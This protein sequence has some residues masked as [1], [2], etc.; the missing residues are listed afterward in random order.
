ML[1]QT[2]L[3]LAVLLVV[4]F[5]EAVHESLLLHN[6]SSYVYYIKILKSDWLSA[7]LISALIGQWIRF[8][9]NP[10]NLLCMQQFLPYLQIVAP[11]GI[12]P[13]RRNPEKPV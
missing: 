2:G 8:L 3:T 7:V 9:Y 13:R 1:D 6:I 4:K 11:A 10:I 12:S 5:Y